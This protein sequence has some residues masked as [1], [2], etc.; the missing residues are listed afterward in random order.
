MHANGFFMYAYH[1]IVLLAH[2]SINLGQLLKPQV[3][4]NYGVRLPL[5]QKHLPRTVL[6]FNVPIIKTV[7]GLL[8]SLCIAVTGSVVL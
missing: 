6:L 5:L 3:F 8:F 1:I 7:L 2:F 4:C